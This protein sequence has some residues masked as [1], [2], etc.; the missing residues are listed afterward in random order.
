[1]RLIKPIA[2]PFQEKGTLHLSEENCWQL[3]HPE[4]A[5][6]VCIEPISSQDPRHPNLSVS[7]ISIRLAIA[8]A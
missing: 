4:G 5:S 6:F 8:H 7:A 3:Y 1:M 2:L